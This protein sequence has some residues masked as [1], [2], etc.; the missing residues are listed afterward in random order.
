MDQTQAERACSVD[1]LHMDFGTTQLQ[2][3]GAQAE[4][5]DRY[6]L[7]NLW[8]YLAPSISALGKAVTAQYSFDR[9][10]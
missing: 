1:M 3:A 4:H 10:L 7:T 9:A 6:Q 5:S 2:F 8:G